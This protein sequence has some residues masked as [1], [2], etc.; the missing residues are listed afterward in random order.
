FS[1]P[2]STDP[3]IHYRDYLEI[4]PDAQVQTD[5]SGNL[6]CLSGLPFEPERQV[7]VK[8]GLPAQNGERTTYDEHFILT[9][10]DRPAYVGFAGNGVILPRS[11]ADGLAIESVNVSKLGIEVL[12]VPDRI[13]SQRDIGP[14]EVFEEGGWGGDWVD[15]QDVGVSVYKGTIDVD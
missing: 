12:R 14:G 6:L 10:G 5:I 7:T 15:G 13:L 11:E 4:D 3:S 1:R 9:F 8:T 2:L